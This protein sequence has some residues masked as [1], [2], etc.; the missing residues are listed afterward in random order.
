MRAV[1][2]GD[3]G[4]LGRHFTRKLKA[5]GFDVL[6]V[7]V[8]RGGMRTNDC[9]YL[10]NTSTDRYDLAIHAAAVVGGR[11]AIEGRPL[12]LTV[13]FDLDLAYMRWLLATRPRHAVYFSSSAVYPITL[14]DTDLVPRQLWEHDLNTVKYVGVPD[15]IYGWTKLVGEELMRRVRDA[16]VDVTVVRPFSGYGADQDLTY[17][18][19]TFIRRGLACAADPELPFDVWGPGTQVRDFVHVDDVVAATLNAVARPDVQVTNVCTG[20]ATSFVDLARE[21]LKQVAPT[22]EPNRIVTHPAKPTGVAYRVGSPRQMFKFYAPK[23]SL[24]EGI[25]SALEVSRG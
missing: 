23:V 11:E 15:E 25:T 17:P 24:P 2:T 5:C 4:F 19:P 1:V 14:Q 9:R 18:F 22:R 3:L 7:D 10:F 12:D 6:G 8:K 13:N 16:G 20:I 21:V